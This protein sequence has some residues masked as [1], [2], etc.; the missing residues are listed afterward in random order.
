M[1]CTPHQVK[2]NKMGGVCGMYGGQD[3]CTQGF[4]GE[5]WWKE[6]IWKT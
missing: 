5:T 4:G 6:T 3:T 2:K 1:I